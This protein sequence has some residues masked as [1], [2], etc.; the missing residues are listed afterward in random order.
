MKQTTASLRELKS[1]LSHYLRLVKGGETVEI[2]ERRTPVARL[3]PTAGPMAGRLAALAQ[4]G[5]VLWSKCRLDPTAPVAR[6][7]GRRAVADL[8]IEDRG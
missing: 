7:R 1:R 8:L 4:S 2:A 5:L 6:V 3:V